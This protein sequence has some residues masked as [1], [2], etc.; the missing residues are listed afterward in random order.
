MAEVKVRAEGLRFPEGPVALADGSVLV[1]EVERGTLTKV[2]PAGEREVVAECGGGPNGAAAGPDGRIYVAN[3]GG[4]D[5]DESAGFLVCV[6][7]SLPIAGRIEAVDIATGE[8]ETLYTEC[9]GR[10]LEAPNDIVFDAAGGFYFTDSGHWR[11]RVEQSGAIY[12]AQPDGSGIV[13]AVDSFPAPNGIGL[14]PDG[15]RL[16]V[17]S[18]QAGRLWYWE[19]ESPGRPPRRQDLL[20]PRRSE[21]PLEPGDLRPPRLPRDRRRGQRLP[22]QHPQRHLRRQPLAATSSNTFDR[23]PLHHQHLLR[24]PRPPHRLRH[25]R[26][27]RQALRDRPGPAPACPSTSTSADLPFFFVP[28]VP[29]KV[30]DHFLFERIDDFVE[31]LRNLRDGEEDRVAVVGDRVDVATRAARRDRSAP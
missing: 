24:R 12:Y 9:D 31:A 8:A 11:G 1:C 26:R 13:A 6:A 29:V 7:C 5:W 14:S 4:F 3:N 16:Y 21:L 22:G 15:S 2:T 30:E 23:R 17:S 25:R 19:V 20:R 10:P 28:G 18:T 27:P